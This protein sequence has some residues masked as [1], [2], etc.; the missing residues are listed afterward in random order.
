MG[1]GMTIELSFASMRQRDTKYYREVVMSEDYWDRRRRHLNEDHKFRRA[2]SKRDIEIDKG[3]AIID[4]LSGEISRRERSEKLKALLD[5][6]HKEKM[7]VLKEISACSSLRKDKWRE[8]L[9]SIDLMHLGAD[10]EL[11]NLLDEVERERRLWSS[12]PFGLP[13]WWKG[14]TEAENRLPTRPESTD[15]RRPSSTLNAVELGWERKQR[16][17]ALEMELKEIALAGIVSSLGLLISTRKLYESTR[18]NL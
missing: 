14:L 6:M 13:E 4:R 10:A 11:K 2:Q 7:S 5:R 15:K 8:H 9:N 12:K 18:S 17:K 3:K 16:A 1:S